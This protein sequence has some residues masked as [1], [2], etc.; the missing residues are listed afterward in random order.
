[1]AKQIKAQAASK[2]TSKAA[3]DGTPKLGDCLRAIRDR[4]GLS[5]ADVSAATG[6]ARS[7]LSRVEADQLS[8]TYDKLVQ[9]SRGLKID[10]VELLTAQSEDSPQPTLTRRTH[11]EPGSGRVLAVG[12]SVYRYM[13]TELAT[14]RMTPMIVEVTA[15]TIEQSN[16]LLAHPGEEFTYVISGTAELH[17]EFY[18]P[19]VLEAGS[20]A[21]FDS[22]MRHTYI[23]I[24]AQPAQILCVCSADDAMLR[25]SLAGAQE[26]QPLPAPRPHIEGHPAARRTRRARNAS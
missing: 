14:K 3:P 12:N 17:T 21:Y 18:Q 4:R 20:C 1:M 19:L 25:Q 24:G 23:A 8:L 6:I 9:L 2:R 11:S 7:T 15:R 22:S 13:C 5:L 16:G 26:P 10:L